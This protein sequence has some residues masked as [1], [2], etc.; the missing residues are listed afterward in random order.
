V[1]GQNSAILRADAGGRAKARM[2]RRTG[3]REA[4]RITDEFALPFYEGLD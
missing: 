3:R 1:S 4:L 2:R